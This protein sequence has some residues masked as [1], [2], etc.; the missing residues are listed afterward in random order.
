MNQRH[1]FDDPAGGAEWLGA[2]EAAAALGIKRASLYA[3]AS[4][5]LVRT[6]PGGR[7]RERRYLRADLLRLKARRDARSGHG[8]VAAGALRF[9]EP[10]L[11]S[12]LTAILPSGHRY[13][14]RS[15]AELAEQATFEQVAELLFT[16]TLPAARPE[17]R[18]VDLG[19]PPKELMALL[20]ATARPLDILQ[21]YLATLAALDPRRHDPHEAAAIVRGRALI[22]R[23]AAALALPQGR[24]AVARALAATTVAE[25]LLVAFGKTPTSAK[26]RELDRALV[27]VADHE[28]NPS[29][30]VARIPASVGADLYASAIAALATLSGPIHGAGCDWVEALFERAAGPDGAVKIVRE[31]LRR[32][33]VLPGF[34]H[35]LYPAGDP[36]A[37]ILLA[38]AEALAPTAR[39]V[40]AARAFVDS[41]A[42]AGYEPPTVDVG[43][44]ALAAALRLPAG[45]ALAI[46]AIGRMAGWIAHALEQRRAGF[47]LR[48]R[49][50][51]TASI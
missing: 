37:R 14:D 33:E 12:S 13:R 51:Y 27:L 4:R 45:S 50:R 11:E 26:A 35:R 28:L 25:S 42:L 43:L 9:G 10:V 17:W 1:R 44:V 15:A 29:S 23:A 49:A 40:R 3:Y 20:P 22:R 5:G 21:V 41:V 24:T 19:A 6:A 16:G 18:A 46:F 38:R 36:R 30:F 34:G 8:A 31:H 48:P 39:T 47:V 7:A 32:G 2:E